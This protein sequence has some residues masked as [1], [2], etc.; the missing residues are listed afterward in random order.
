MG[1]I[2]RRLLKANKKQIFTTALAG[3][4]FLDTEEVRWESKEKNN[5]L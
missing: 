3:T 2:S 5:R 4:G 1:S